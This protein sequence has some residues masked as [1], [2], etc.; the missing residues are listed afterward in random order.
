MMNPTVFIRVESVIWNYGKLFQFSTILL[1]I[2]NVLM[3]VE[4]E[5]LYNLNL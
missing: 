4:K 3:L 2:E 1:E 5:L